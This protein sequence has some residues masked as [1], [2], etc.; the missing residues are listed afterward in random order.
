M[1][2]I[3]R[4]RTTLVGVQGAPYYQN[5]F[6]P[7]AMTSQEVVDRTADFWSIVDNVMVDECAWNVDP[8]V[9]TINDATGEVTAAETVNGANG[10]GLSTE[11]MLPPSNQ[12]L[13]QWRTG[14]FVSGRELRGRTNVPALGDDV[15]TGGVPDVTVRGAVDTALEAWVVV[16]ADPPL[17]WSR[18]HGV[19]HEVTSL[20]V[21]NQ[22][23]QLHSRRD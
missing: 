6:W 15:N 16:D 1:A 5:M 10:Q 23:A 12:L 2:S 9:L 20:T 11:E 21:W 18:T 17:I 22:F 19:S 13:I 8:V 14:Q 7:E 3:R 4:V